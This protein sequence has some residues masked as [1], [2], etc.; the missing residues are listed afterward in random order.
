MNKTELL[1]GIGFVPAHE[2]SHAF[3]YV[4]SQFSGNTEPSPV[5]SD[6][7]I[8]RFIAK[9]SKLADYYSSIEIEPGL[10]VNGNIVKGEAAADLSGMQA[11]LALAEK[12]DD[13]DIEN[14]IRCMSKTWA[15][16]VPETY[17][18]ALLSDTH[19]LNYLRINV[20]AQMYESVYEAL[21]KN[22]GDGMYL[23]P[24]ERIVFW[25]SAAA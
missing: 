7:D 6:E 24:E 12:S 14:M 17:L 18:F 2:I 10:N 25:G 20:N 21:G 4:G 22:K 19:P 1:G 15:Q 13:I 3:D 11:I 8:D 16:V 5:Y 23:A 9:S